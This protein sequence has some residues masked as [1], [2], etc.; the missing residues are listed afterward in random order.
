MRKPKYDIRINPSDIYEILEMMEEQNLFLIKNIQE[1]ELIAKKEK[2]IS[3]KK[4]K[5][6]KKEV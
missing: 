6:M 5:L 2:K 4:I 1:D 3:K